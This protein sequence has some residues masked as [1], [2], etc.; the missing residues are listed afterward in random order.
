MATWEMSTRLRKVHGKVFHRKAVK[1]RSRKVQKA[2]AYII[3]W[4]C[5][6]KREMMMRLRKVHGKVFH[7]RR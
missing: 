2:S 4:N 5:N 7:R 6:A 3:L 1:E